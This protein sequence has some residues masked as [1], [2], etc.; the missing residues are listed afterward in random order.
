MATADTP[1]PA[2]DVIPVR[3]GED[4]DRAALA[5]YLRDKLPNASGQPA[6][7]QFG[8]GH[9]NLTYLLHYQTAGGATEFVLR[10][11]PIGPVAATSHDMGREYR[12]LSVLYRAFPLAP[13]AYLCCEDPSVI[14]APFLVM[15]R[16][17]GIVVRATI[18]PE[19]GDGNDP[20]ATRK[21]SEAVIDTLADLHQVD[22]TAV[23]LEALGKP[24]GFMQRQVTGWTQRWERAKTGEVP[25]ATEISDWLS[26]KLPPSPRPV[27]VHND[28]RLDNMMLA[29]DDP[30][31][32]VAVFD[33]DMC[34]IGDPLADV[35]TLLAS[36]FEADEEV[37]PWTPMPS[38]MPGFITRRQAV[39]RYAARTGIDVSRIGY[40]RVFGTFK[41]AVVLQQ[42]YYRY[43]CGQTTDERFRIFEPMVDRLLELASTVAEQPDA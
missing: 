31:R 19:F 36:W 18:P 34:T 1:P 21:L 5:A 41:M 38:T 7:W 14:G 23:G 24:E 39:A 35:G 27:L 3:E 13:R 43:H 29:P 8:G 42:I 2:P 40:Y 30:G 4:F 25:L 11:P 28:W 32:V 15:E 12:V 6:V 37:G 33:W 16:R 20:T 17:Q 26:R 10:R 9:A 22:P